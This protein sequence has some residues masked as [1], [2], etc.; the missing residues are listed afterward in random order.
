MPDYTPHCPA[1]EKRLLYDTT[2]QADVCVVGAGTSGLAAATATAR[3]GA[4]VLLVERS[5][6]LGGLGTGAA[7]GVFCGMYTRSAAPRPVPAWF[8]GTIVDRLRRLGACY[9]SP[10][11][12]TTLVHYDP[13]VLKTVYDDI[14]AEHGVGL[15]THST[16]VAATRTGRRAET[17]TVVTPGRTRRIAAAEWIDASGDAALCVRLGIECRQQPG[18]QTQPATLIFRMAGVDSARGPSRTELND[19]MRA[20][21]AGGRYDLPRTSGSFYPTVHDGEVVVN[22]TRVRVN[23]TDVDELAAA[24]AA[25]CRQVREY[26]CWL[27]E[28]VSGFEQAHVSAVA[29]HL[30]IR[31]SRR[32]AGR[33]VLDADMLRGGRRTA[34]DLGYGAWPLEIHDPGGSGTLIEWLP[35]DTLYGVPSDATRPQDLDNVRVV[36]RCMST[37]AEAHASTRVM[38]TCFSVGE[39]AGAAAAHAARNAAAPGTAVTES[40]ATWRAETTEPAVPPTAGRLTTGSRSRGNADESTWYRI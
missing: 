31:E 16:L 1:K 19:R 22:M 6:F 9:Q 18:N 30:G 29:S 33:L 28:R 8:G 3:S 12:T 25:A 21:A 14:V 35:D 7:M 4:R 40:L 20:D 13:D 17:A 23:G 34:T 32:L 38:G 39:G 5:G 11:G 26:A 2:D 36:G 24:E 37:T 27:I 10:F 15:L